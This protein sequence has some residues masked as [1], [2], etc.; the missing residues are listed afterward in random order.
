MDMTGVIV[1]LLIACLVLISICLGLA[2]GVLLMLRRRATQV[3]NHAVEGEQATSEVT[4]QEQ[5]DNQILA[6]LKEQTASILKEIQGGSVRQLIL[7]PSGIAIGMAIALLTP[8]TDLT[9]GI[10]LAILGLFGLFVG[11]LAPSWW[12]T[13]KIGFRKSRGGR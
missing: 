2:L 6:G 10:I 5:P 13:R 11:I 8:R 7:A 4:K 9:A 12:L 3:S 1:I